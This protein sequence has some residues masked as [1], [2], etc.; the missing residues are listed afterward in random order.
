M[1]VYT[2]K[3]IEYPTI[4][5]EIKRLQ[6]CSKTARQF[7]EEYLRKLYKLLDE[8]PET[9]SFQKA[10]DNPD[11]DFFSRKALEYAGVNPD[12]CTP[13]LIEKLLLPSEQSSLGFIV[14]LNFSGSAE[15]PQLSDCEG[16]EGISGVEIYY[17][18]LASLYLALGSLSEAVEILDSLPG[19]AVDHIL[20]AAFSLKKE[21]TETTSDK[22]KKKAMAEMEKIRKDSKLPVL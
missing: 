17:K 14:D 15:K 10:L 13:M 1:R 18:T 2:E 20:E 11:I 5:G 22:F 6:P 8:L 7:L 19:P 16:Q 3:H 4:S 12:E 9:V 21:S